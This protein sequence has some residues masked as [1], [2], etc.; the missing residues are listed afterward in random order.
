MDKEFAPDKGQLPSKN[1]MLSFLT[2]KKNHEGADF[3]HID[4]PISLNSI[5]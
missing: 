2:L 3:N 1:R 5:K 4:P